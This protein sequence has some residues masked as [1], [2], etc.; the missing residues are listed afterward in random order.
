MELNIKFYD[1][2]LRLYSNR[3]LKT[4]NNSRNPE[5]NCFCLVCVRVRERLTN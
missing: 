2:S 5:I 4:K 1:R 3:D